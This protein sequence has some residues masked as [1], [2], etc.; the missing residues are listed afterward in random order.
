MERDMADEFEFHL[1]QRAADLAARDGLSLAEARRRAR[2]EFGSVEKYKEEARQGLGLRLIDEVRGDLRHACRTLGRSRGFTAAALVTLALGIG[3]N[4]AV[5]SAVDALLLRKLPVKNPD[6]LVMFDWLR[7]ADSMVASHSGYGRPGPGSGVGIRTSFS[8]LTVE[9]FRQQSTTL[10][11]VFAFSPTALNVVADQQADW[12]SGLIVSGNYFA[13]L[14]VSA[15]AGRTLTMSDDRPQA[16]PVAV[17]SYRYWQ[18]RFAGDPGVVGKAIELNRSPAVIVGVT[19]EGFDGP[20][21][22]KSSDIT[23]P[24]ATAARVNR[25]AAVRPVSVWWLQMMGRLRPGATREQALAELRPMFADTVR[26]AWAARP[27]DTPNPTRTGMP[28]LRV[29]PGARGPDGPRIDMQEILAVV[30]A[31]VAATF[32]I[33]C[34]NLANLLLVRASVRRQEISVRLTLGASRWRIVRQLITETLLLAVAGGTGGAILAAWGKDFMKWL[35]LPDVP[36]VDA[37]LDLRVL[38]FTAGLS[39]LTT[40]AFG[41]V[42]ALRTAR[43]DVAP[44]L[45]TTG[46]NRPVARSLATKALLVVQVAASLVLIFAAGLLVRTLYN[47]SRVDVGFNPDRLLVFQIDPMLP[48]DNSRRA[49]DMYDRIMASIEALPG[50]EACTMSVMPLIARSQWDDLVLADGASIQKDAFIQVVR[51]NFLDAIGIPVFLGR[52]LTAADKQGRPR[53]AVINETMARD[54]FGERNPVGRRFHFVNGRDRDVPI[55]VIGVARDSRYASLDEPLPPTLYMPH[56]QVPPGGMHVEVRTASD[57][58]AI[59]P[60][61]RDAIRRID[62]AIPIANMTTEREQIA[63]TIAKPRAFAV[64]TAIS[65]VTGLLLAC[66]GLYG[67]VSYDTIRRTHEIGIRMA[68]GARRFDVLRLVIR[69]IAVIVLVGAVVG[70]AASIFA[71]RLIAGLLFGITPTDPLTIWTALVLL[72]AVALAAAYIPARRAAG[73]D[74]AQALRYE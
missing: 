32:L 26:E 40:L 61:V 35:P 60:A 67:I 51:W 39:A 42:P 66:V 15:I 63:D 57:P 52:D 34:V 56:E 14:G 70:V 31:A 10:S 4:T 43:T 71:S 64:L 23:L 18:R 54:V 53:V 24:I 12:V 50:V 38:A 27:P 45:R 29:R 11:D 17:V 6:E 9:R 5:F 1:Q 44:S 7:T 65:G 37:R 13:A 47:F 3:A 58:L 30:F 62:P 74:P 16:D 48:G 36:T 28:Q 49:F 68:L 55:E 19:P 41:I 2:L 69:Q 59:A 20:Q 22:S 21:V 33:A 8:E 72:S 46:Q 73:L 25:T